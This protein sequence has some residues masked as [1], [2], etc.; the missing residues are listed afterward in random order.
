MEQQQELIQYL[1]LGTI[2]RLQ[3]GSKRLMIYGRVQKLPNGK[4]YDYLGVP[5]P[6]GFIHPDK[7]FVFNHHAIE[8]VAH[9]GFIDEED[10]LIQG[11]LQ[12]HRPLTLEAPDKDQ[13]KQ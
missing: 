3:G 9:L 1:P 2:V 7:S 11:L 10:E 4:E 8:E 12:Q 13:G 6:E 5:Y